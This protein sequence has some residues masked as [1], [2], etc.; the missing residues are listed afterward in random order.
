MIR[1]VIVKDRFFRLGHST[2]KQ[3]LDEAMSQVHTVRRY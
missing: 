3:S 2:V 1:F